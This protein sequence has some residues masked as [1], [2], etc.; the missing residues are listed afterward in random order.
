[1][2]KLVDAQKS[3]LTKAAA[4]ENGAATPPAKVNKSAATKLATKLVALK[5]MREILTK[6]D[7]PVWRKDSDGRPTSFVITRAGRKAVEEANSIASYV[8][9]QPSKS[10]KARLAADDRSSTVDK[11]LSTVDSIKSA[12]RNVPRASSKQALVLD[13]LKRPEGATLAALVGA[14]GWLPHTTR[15]ALTVLRR[16]GFAIEREAGQGGSASIYRIAAHVQNAA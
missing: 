13:M 10:G 2:T 14:T 4:R 15:A 7:M 6:P 12:V 9:S 11:N 1:M 5:L 16:R 3:L 8:E